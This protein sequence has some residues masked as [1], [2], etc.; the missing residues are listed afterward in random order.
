MMTLLPLKEMPL[1]DAGVKTHRAEGKISGTLSTMM[2]STQD[3]LKQEVVLEVTEVSEE[4]EVSEAEEEA[5]VVAIGA[6]SMLTLEMVENII[7]GRHQWFIMITDM[8]IE[9]EHLVR[10][11]IRVLNQEVLKD[12]KDMK[13]S[14][15]EEML[16]EECPLEI[17]IQ[18]DLLQCKWEE[19]HK[20]VKDTISSAD[21]TNITMTITIM[22]TR[23]TMADHPWKD[24][25]AEDLAAW[26]PHQLGTTINHNTLTLSTESLESQE[27]MGDHPREEVV[28]MVDLIQE[29]WEG[30]HKTCMI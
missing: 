21:T 16:R 3:Q 11:D 23:I 18:E 24:N 13:R 10:I 6:D 27:K 12:M 29:I 9:E 8:I 15:N 30:H 20:E 19:A 5:T 26:D 4:A 25:S 1:A 7:K 2:R 28:P 17:S 14:D 22:V